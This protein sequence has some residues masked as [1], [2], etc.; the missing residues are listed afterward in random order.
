MF[1]SDWNSADVDAFCNIVC[2]N[3]VLTIGAPT[4]PTLSNAICYEMDTL[5][6]APTRRF[7]MAI[8]TSRNFGKKWLSTLP[9]VGR[10]RWILSAGAL[11]V[12]P[13]AALLPV[14]L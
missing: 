1:F 11:R 8:A 5:H 2:R 6:V 14:T 4:S 13:R 9:G 3:S 10:E 12:L 7:D